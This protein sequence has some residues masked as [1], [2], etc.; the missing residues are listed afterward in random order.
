MNMIKTYKLTTPLRS[1]SF[2]LRGK[3][4]NSLRYNFS[5]GD[6]LTGKAATLMLR[7]QYAQD[8]LESSDLFKSGYVVLVR[9]DQGGESVK[10]QERPVA[11]IE[12]IT[13][14]EQLIE[15][16]A[17]KLEKMYQRPEAALEY[18]KKN[19]FEFP[20]LVLKKE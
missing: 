6:P 19:G 10:T 4:N 3:S 14:S 5:G 18:A 17:E 20:N 7:S 12:D 1:N 11:K 2:V 15:F 16:V 13:P 8:L 9:T